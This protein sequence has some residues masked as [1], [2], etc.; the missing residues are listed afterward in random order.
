MALD[1]G[2]GSGEA[3]CEIFMAEKYILLQKINSTI[4]YSKQSFEQEMSS[5]M[6]DDEIWN[7]NFFEN[8]PHGLLA[9][10]KHV[11]ILTT[12]LKN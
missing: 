3:A 5:N 11:K 7:E 1:L 2:K 6:F 8:H 12:R 4:S 9:F 10:I